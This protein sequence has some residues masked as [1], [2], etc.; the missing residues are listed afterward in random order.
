MACDTKLFLGRTNWRDRR[1]LFGVQQRDRLMHLY[2]VGQTGTGKS[3]FLEYLIAQDMRAERGLAF[4]DPHG[5]TVERLAF[6]AHEWLG[7][8][9]VY[10]NAPDAACPVAFTGSPGAVVPA[11]V[12]CSTA[13]KDRRI[14]HGY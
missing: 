2:A 8:R 1:R 5:D 7:D 3:T 10:L 4:L 13:R 12:R 14:V 6:E 11:S 9:L